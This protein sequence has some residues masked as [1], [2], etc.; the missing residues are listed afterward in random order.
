MSEALLVDL[1]AGGSGFFGPAVVESRERWNDSVA[2]TI[3]E[4]LAVEVAEGVDARRRLVGLMLKELNSKPHSGRAEKLVNTLLRLLLWKK[5]I[6]SEGVGS[7]SQL[8]AEDHGEIPAFRQAIYEVIVEQLRL[9]RSTKFVRVELTVGAVTGFSDS[10]ADFT[11]EFNVVGD[12]EFSVVH[13]QFGKVRLARSKSPDAIKT[14][15]LPTENA[16]VEPLVY[17]E[18]FANRI[19]FCLNPSRLD[20]SQVEEFVVEPI[21]YAFNCEG[22]HW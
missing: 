22:L 17:A 13:P 15:C 12:S 19:R 6:D 10:T 2:S 5:D 9:N 11:V 16:R 3:R 7:F 14:W 20:V 8:I 18:L 1:L 21:I 4:L